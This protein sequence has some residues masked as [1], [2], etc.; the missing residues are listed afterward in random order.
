MSANW[1]LFVSRGELETDQVA[2]CPGLKTPAQ[3]VFHQ[4]RGGTTGSDHLV[5]VVANPTGEVGSYD[6][7]I[8]IK[9]TPAK[10][11]N[12]GVSCLMER[13]GDKDRKRPD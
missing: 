3:V 1:Q 7:T 2:G 10:P 12:E 9:T 5:Y 13:N 11:R 8:N 4:A 6:V